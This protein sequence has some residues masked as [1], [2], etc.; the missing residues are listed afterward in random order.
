MKACF[1]KSTH[2][3]ETKGLNYQKLSIGVLI[4]KRIGS[5]DVHQLLAINESMLQDFSHGA[6]IS[7]VL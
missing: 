7:L 4:L 6:I 5:Q 1:Y 3:M 2:W